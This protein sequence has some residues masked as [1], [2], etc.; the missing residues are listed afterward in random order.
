MSMLGNLVG[1]RLSRAKGYK[2]GCSKLPNKLGF[3]LGSKEPL[4]V[5]SCWH[6]MDKKR[7][8]PR[9]FEHDLWPIE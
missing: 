5:K 6:F 1:V 9:L 2:A 8:F 7:C 4:P 3:I